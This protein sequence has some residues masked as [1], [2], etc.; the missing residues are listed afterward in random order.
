MLNNITNRYK[1]LDVNS[2][3]NVAKCLAII[4]VIMAHSRNTDFYFYSN[5][6]ERLGAIGVVAFLIISGYYFNVAKYGVMA[7]FKKKINTIIIPWIFTGTVV[8]FVSNKGDNLFFSDWINWIIGNGTYLYY[9]LILLL[10]YLLL[11]FFNKRGYLI[12]F[13]LLN[14]ISLLLTC[15]G[16]FNYIFMKCFN[17]VEINNYLNV[18][19]WIGYFSLGIFLKGHLGLLME[20]LKKYRLVI[21]LIYILALCMSFYLEPLNA[22]YFSKLAIPMQILGVAFIFSMSTLKELNNSVVTKV[23][24]LTFAIYLTHFLIFPIRKFLITSALLEFINPV[25][26]L[27]INFLILLTGSYISQRI[28]WYGLYCL[29][30]GIRRTR[31][32]EKEY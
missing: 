17:D 13:I 16:V 30:L 32:I 24:E 18:F 7:F 22:G 25:I 11:S 4:S 10:C 1:S 26:I 8:F 19:N 23:A 14:I 31:V 20:F 5:I 27:T 2:Y 28:K 15:F 21:A 6:T 12:L 3:M 9:L 29:L